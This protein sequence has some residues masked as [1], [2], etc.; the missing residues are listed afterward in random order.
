[1]FL[2]GLIVAQSTRGIENFNLPRSEVEKDGQDWFVSFFLFLHHPKKR[3]ENMTI[4]SFAPPQLSCQKEKFSEK[5]S[6]GYFSSP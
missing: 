4:F 5:I 3:S 2:I 1:M 6:D